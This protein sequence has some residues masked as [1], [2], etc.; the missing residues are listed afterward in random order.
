VDDTT[1]WDAV[2]AAAGVTTMAVGVATPAAA[3]GVA[4]AIADVDVVGFALAGLSGTAVGDAACAAAFTPQSIA[5]APA[6]IAPPK[7][8]RNPR[9][10]ASLPA[11]F[12]PPQSYCERA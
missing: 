2:A 12:P 11:S 7:A 10:I 1:G 9:F 6:R 3:A 8:S 4:V 5:L